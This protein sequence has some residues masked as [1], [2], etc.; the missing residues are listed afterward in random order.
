[1]HNWRAMPLK[2]RFFQIPFKEKN[3]IGKIIGFIVIK[4]MCKSQS[5]V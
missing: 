2:Q 3:S 5:E 1:M 4:R